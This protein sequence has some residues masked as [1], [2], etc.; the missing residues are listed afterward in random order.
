M[1]YF[2]RLRESVPQQCFAPR[3]RYKWNRAWSRFDV[4]ARP[5]P[6][7]QD[8]AHAIMRKAAEEVHAVLVSQGKGIDPMVAAHLL[9]V[10]HVNMTLFELAGLRPQN[11]APRRPA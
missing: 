3:F 7:W 9:K 4:L 6:E 10:V 11:R 1:G 2:A 8:E 5:N